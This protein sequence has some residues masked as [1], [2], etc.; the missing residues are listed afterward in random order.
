MTQQNKTIEIHIPSNMGYEKIAMESGAAVAK[1]MLF[2]DD[3]IND[4]KTAI[5]EACMNAIEH[6]NKTSPTEKV[7]VT[8]TVDDSKLQIDVK[9]KGKPFAPVTDK[10]DIKEKIEGKEETRG[11]GMFL[12]KNLVDE[13]EF[14][15]QPEGNT[16]RMIIYLHK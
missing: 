15:S 6:G 1:L 10:P 14:S 11:W 7:F 3:R 13:V 8:L 16:T 2:S 12:I 5:A 4:L 9:D